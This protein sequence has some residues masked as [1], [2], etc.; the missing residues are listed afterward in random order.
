MRCL[1]KKR[2]LVE[3]A[4]GASVAL[5]YDGRLRQHLKGFSKDS[6][7]VLVVC[8]GSRIDLEMMDMYKVKFGAR[9][10][11]LGLTTSRDVP[12]TYTAM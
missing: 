10:K 11:E 6:V 5:A 8:G 1:R 2:I 4:C 3:P 7:V 12:S 9:V